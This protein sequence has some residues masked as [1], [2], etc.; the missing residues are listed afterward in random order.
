MNLSTRI[1][2]PV[3]AALVLS[4]GSLTGYGVW[5]QYQL[6][7]TQEQERLDVLANVFSDRLNSQAE[8]AVALAA[9]QRTLARHQ[10]REIR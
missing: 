1:L 2:V 9:S 8:S 3:I 6:I 5:S 7:D 4:V 10:T